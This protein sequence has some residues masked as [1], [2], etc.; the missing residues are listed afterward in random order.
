[1]NCRIFLIQFLL[2]FITISCQKYDCTDA[3][4]KD[5]I[6]QISIYNLKFLN[7]TKDTLN[8]NF[9]IK[10][11]DNFLNSKEI[12]KILLPNDSTIYYIKVHS[13]SKS[14][15]KDAIIKYYTFF[16]QIQ[17]SIMPF[18]EIAYDFYYDSNASTTCN[19]KLYFS[20]KRI[21]SLEFQNFITKDT[22]DKYKSFYNVHNYTKLGKLNNEEFLKYTFTE[23]DYL[24]A[25]T[26]I[27]Y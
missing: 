12:S 10:H 22:N 11:F 23:K 25:D 7:K 24:L 5:F 27:N 15:N 2:I 21:L 16:S 18:D 13:N 26:I 17:Y 9:R 3:C 8:F 4:G 6:S 14:Y 19:M 20:K 1:M